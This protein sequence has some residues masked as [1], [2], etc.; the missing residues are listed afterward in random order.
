[1]KALAIASV[2]ALIAFLVGLDWSLQRK[3]RRFEEARAKAAQEEAVLSSKPPP[4][5][6]P[7]DVLRRRNP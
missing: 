7:Y 4:K 1:M 3:Q 5:L 2:I 6:N